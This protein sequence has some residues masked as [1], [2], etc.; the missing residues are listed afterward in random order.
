MVGTPKSNAHA[1][2]QAAIVEQER[3]KRG[4]TGPA[5]GLLI[6]VGTSLL[7]WAVLGELARL[8]SAAFF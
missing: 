6:A 2:S 8:M 3:A 5:G 4:S 1:A 7:L